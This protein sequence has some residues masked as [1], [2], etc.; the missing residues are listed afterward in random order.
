MRIMQRELRPFRSKLQGH[1]A[2]D[3]GSAARYYGHPAV[4]AQRGG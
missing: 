2:A 1:P 4:E 3:P